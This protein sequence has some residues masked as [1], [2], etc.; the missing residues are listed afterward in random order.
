MSSEKFISTWTRSD[1]AGYLSYL[2]DIKVVKAK[3]EEAISEVNDLIAHIEASETYT[4]SEK[5]VIIEKAKTSKVYLEKRLEV[6]LQRLGDVADAVYEEFEFRYGAG[7]ISASGLTDP[8][9]KIFGY[10]NG[11]CNKMENILNR[12]YFGE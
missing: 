10:Y 5:L 8:S 12:M 3:T 7:S 1:N 9:T 6:T 11:L 4:A 2:S